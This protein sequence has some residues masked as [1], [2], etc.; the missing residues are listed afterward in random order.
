MRYARG[1]TIGVVLGFLI[2]CA[3]IAAWRNVRTAPVPA[4]QARVLPVTATIVRPTRVPANLEAIGSLRAVREVM[5]APE[6]AGRVV[7]IHFEAGTHVNAGQPLVDL[8]EGPELADRASAQAQAHFA[9]IQLDR[10]RKLAP[11]HV[12]PRETLDQ[13]EA[14]LE[15]AQASVR[16]L[17]A[18]IEQH[19]IRAPFGGQLGIRRINLGQYLNA[20]DAIATLTDLDQLYVEF[21]LPQ[22]DLPQVRVGSEVH[23][24]ADAWPGRVF[25]AKVNALEPKVDEQTRNVTVQALLANPQHE[26][27]PGMY[28]T[29]ALDLPPQDGALVVPLTAI[30]TAAIGDTVVVI[31][32]P[33]A[34]AEG[35][36]QAVP[37]TTGRRVAD[38]VV[39]TQG[40]KAGDVVVTEG[41]IR[42]QPGVR[43]SVKLER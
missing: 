30:Q 9:T 31:R 24:R 14:E 1:P 3:G 37:V 4:A 23:V 13:H 16:Q 33:N 21:N 8:F 5:L 39:V 25:L 6:V 18:R 29:A 38:K 34:Q 42:L 20:G 28:V 12:E 22:Q 41:Q 35:E 43:V 26:L 19:H 15:Q 32:G 2:L 40:L 17:D 11:S 36:A 27:H 7:A 10:S